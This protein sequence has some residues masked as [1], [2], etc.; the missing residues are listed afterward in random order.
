M[1][2][3]DLELFKKHTRTDDFNGDD[4]LLTHYLETAEEEVIRSV[5]R[6]REELCSINGGTFPKGL[7]QAIMVLAAHWYNQRESVSGV[8]M[9]SVPD[10]LQALLKPWRKFSTY[11]SGQDEL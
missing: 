6:S 7:V 5:N 1:P 3:V 8:Q 10:S 9:H 11:A 2:V 4:V